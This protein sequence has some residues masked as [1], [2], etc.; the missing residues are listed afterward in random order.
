MLERLIGENNELVTELDTDLD[1]IKA[2]PGQISQVIM[3]L[4][5][6]SRDAMPDGGRL[7]LKT[8]NVEITKIDKKIN[9]GIF[10]GKYI[11]LEVSDTGIG[12]NDEIKSHIFDRFFLQKNRARYRPWACY[13]V[14][15]CNTK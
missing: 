14:W 6:N 11:K 7:V 8:D 5:V 12:M 4:S 15:Y 2:D 10:P 3:N 1:L 13:S 9:P